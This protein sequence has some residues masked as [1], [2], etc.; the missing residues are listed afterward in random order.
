VLSLGGLGA[1]GCRLLGEQARHSTTGLMS[2]LLD[3]G[4]VEPRGRL[5]DREELLGNHPEELLKTGVLGRIGGR[6]TEHDDPP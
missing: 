2:P 1:L 3:R 6:T 5:V 4:E